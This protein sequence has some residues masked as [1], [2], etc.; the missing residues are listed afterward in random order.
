MI[1]AIFEQAL[2]FLPFALGVYLSFALL[3]IPDLTVDG[4]FVLGAALFAKGGELGMSPV[5]ALLVAVLA[6]TFVGLIVASVQRGGRIHPLIVGILACFMLQSVT[7]LLMGRP[8][9]PLRGFSFAGDSMVQLVIIAAL[10][11]GGLHLLLTR[12]IG[13][14]L[15]AFGSGAPLLERMGLGKERYRMLGLAGG[16]ALVALSGCLAAQ[17]QGFADIGMGR[18]QV[19]VGVSVVLLGMAVQQQIAPLARGAIELCCCL[20]GTLLYFAVVNI[21]IGMGIDPLMLK[22]CIGILLLS[23]L[24]LGSRQEV[25]SHAC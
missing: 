23:L 13:L 16:N 15:R 20:A 21:L 11:L 4:T 14:R 1:T 5:I 6:G 25:F 3:R 9:I 7:L 19:L 8:N 12:S 18:G 17:A 24:F 10:L 2:L 22:L